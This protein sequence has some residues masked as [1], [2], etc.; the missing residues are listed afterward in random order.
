MKGSNTIAE[1]DNGTTGVT[2]ETSRTVSTLITTIT[3]QTITAVI[4]I[5]TTL[6]SRII[7]QITAIRPFNQTTKIINTT[8]Q[9][10]HSINLIGR[11]TQTTTGQISIIIIMTI[12]IGITRIITIAKYTV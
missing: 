10:I 7:D 11:I 4:T 2:T 6:M 9:I 8:G 12:E 1:V 5:T 3:A